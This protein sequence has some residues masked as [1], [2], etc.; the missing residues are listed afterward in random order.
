MANRRLPEFAL[1]ENLPHVRVTKAEMQE[2]RDGAEKMGLTITDF[3][4]VLIFR[5]LPKFRMK[6]LELV[7]PSVMAGLCR[8]AGNFRDLYN[9]Y[10]KTE[11]F[12]SARSALI[13]DKI[14]HA[15]DTVDAAHQKYLDGEVFV[16]DR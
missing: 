3:L 1:S 5:R 11:T 15:I 10:D 9:N 14:E 6:K 2:I 7:D 16:D 4:R 8:L 12:D 13:L